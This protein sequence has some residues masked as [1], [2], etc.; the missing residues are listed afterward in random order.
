[1]TLGSLALAV[2]IVQAA[3]PAPSD[4][5][6]STAWRTATPHADASTAGA[7]RPAYSKGEHMIRPPAEPGKKYSIT[8]PWIVSTVIDPKGRVIDLKVV[9]SSVEPA[10]PKYQQIV[11]KE[12]RKWR[13]TPGQVD[14]KPVTF[15]ET[16]R[17]QDK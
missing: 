8:G 3:S 5:E 14:G 4:C 6:W 10:W 15:C 7:T 11:E 12:V 17:I 2:S 9:G 16:L 13:F 1:M